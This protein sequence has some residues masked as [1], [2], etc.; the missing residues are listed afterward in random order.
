MKKHAH[1]KR[2]VA[3]SFSWRI[4]ATLTTITLAWIITGQVNYALTIGGAE[5]FIKMIVYYGHERA[6][7]YIPWGLEQ[8]EK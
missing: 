1:P 6:W 2:S 3:K 5:F 8:Y 4:L 7:A